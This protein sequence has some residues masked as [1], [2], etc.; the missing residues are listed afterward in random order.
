[1][2][3]FFRAIISVAR[4]IRDGSE[5]RDRCLRVAALMVTLAVTVIAIAAGLTIILKGAL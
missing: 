2:D 5:D 1:M 3:E 4:L